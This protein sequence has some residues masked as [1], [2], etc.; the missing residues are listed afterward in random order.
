[1]QM[2]PT[3]EGRSWIGFQ[4]IGGGGAMLGA[5]AF[6]NRG[7]KIANYADTSGDPTASKVYMVIK[8]IFSLPIDAY[9][10][11]GSC[12]ANQEQWHHA[13]AVVKALREEAKDRPGLPVILLLAG[14]K[15]KESHEI[16]QNGLKGL[17]LRWELYGRDYIYNTDY[18]ADRVEDLV[19]QYQLEKYG[20]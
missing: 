5:S 12:L 16:I 10:L 4:G 11:M 18:I 8:S 2:V 3:Y 7:F 9:V 15:E 1:M 20:E 6:I 13:H 14:N 17:P 19:R